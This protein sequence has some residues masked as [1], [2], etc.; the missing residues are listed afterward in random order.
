MTVSSLNHME[1]SSISLIISVFVHPSHNG[2]STSLLATGIE[3]GKYIDKSNDNACEAFERSMTLSSLLLPQ[4]VTL[5]RLTDW[6]AIGKIRDNLSN[7]LL[8]RIAHK[9]DKRTAD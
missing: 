9:H 8:L 3:S 7:A 4:G 5:R 6:H 1:A 2:I